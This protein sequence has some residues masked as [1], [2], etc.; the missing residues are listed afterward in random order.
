V[1]KILGMDD[2]GFFTLMDSSGILRSDLKMTT[3]C[4]VNK[5]EFVALK[6]K[7][8]EEQMAVVVSAQSHSII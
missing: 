4:S 8:E 6:K 7:S 3:A 5:E 2:D 1:L